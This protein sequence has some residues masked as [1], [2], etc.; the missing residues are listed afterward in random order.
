MFI[1]KRE[2]EFKSSNR[3]NDI[4]A[5]QLYSRDRCSPRRR[6][7]N[8]WLRPNTRTDM[9]NLRSIC[10]KTGLRCTPA[11]FWGHGRSVA[12]EDDIG[13]FAGSDGWKLVLA[14]IQNF[15]RIIKN[16]LP[17]VPLFLYGYGMG[18]A[19][20]TQDSHARRRATTPES[21]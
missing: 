8:P 21:C 5:F 17:S 3:K 4:Y 6:S 20:R 13:Y 18:L 7:D 15:T 16:E 10:A 1:T 2:F 19:F 14:D 11:T 12:G 9:T